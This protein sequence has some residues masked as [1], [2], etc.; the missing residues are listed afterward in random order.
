M[1]SLTTMAMVL[2]NLIEFGLGTD[3]S[4]ASTLP[5]TSQ[6]T[7]GHLEFTLQQPAGITGVTTTVEVSGDLTQWQSGSGHTQVLSDSTT[8]ATR[9]LIIRDEHTGAQRFMRIRV[10]R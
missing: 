7:G 8:A 5:I 9:T 1:M 4:I 6:I 2:A 3:P 10:T